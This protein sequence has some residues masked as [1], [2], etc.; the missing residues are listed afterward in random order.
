MPSKRKTKK[1]FT[2]IMLV[3]HRYLGFGL[4]V[5]FLFWFL[6]GFVMMYKDF[7]YLS[8]SEVWKRSEK[9]PYEKITM[10]AHELILAQGLE[11]IAWGSIKVT[12]LLGRPVYRLQDEEGILHCYYA[13]TGERLNRITQEQA[14]E[15]VNAFMNERYE[16]SEV[17]KT[18]Q[19]DQWTPRTR[20]LPYLPAYKVHIDDGEGTVCYISSVT[21]EVFQKL[22]TSDKVWAWLGPIPHWIYFKDLRIH[23]QLW[24]DIIVFLSLLGTI[25]CVAGLYM[26]IA[27]VKT[28][29][30]KWNSF[31][32][33]KKFWFKWHHYTGFAFGLITFTWIL[34][35]LFSM[36]PWR[37]SPSNSLSSEASLTW[38]GGGLNPEVFSIS[39]AQAL[40]ASKGI[41]E[42]ISELAY[43]RFAGQPYY[44]VRM[45][46]A[47]SRL[48][49]ADQ[50][51]QQLPQLSTELYTRQINR[52]HPEEEVL[53]VEVL[54]DY[55]A[56]YYNK[57][58]TKP[59]PVVK[60]SLG[61]D[62]D[63]SYY[64]DPK[65]TKVM[66]KY[67]TKS[68]VNRWLYHGLHSLD[69]PALFFK[70]P[71]WDIII[72]VLLLGGLSVSITGLALTYKWLTRKVKKLT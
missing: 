51:N 33:Y 8:K 45:S 5:L 19:L 58:R 64:I 30:R 22:N 43:M 68:R 55:D 54:Q 3:V 9:V 18:E 65:T 50:T 1:K 42:A 39:P 67:E 47:T 35:G 48:F 56:Y 31:S 32:P 66:M 11:D 61:D 62:K 16:I 14:I 23:T 52:L 53:R 10:T 63:T 29:N 15:I 34:S 69:F 27:R 44:L 26:G 13:D 72:L 46:D 71:L 25:M 57:H 20:F 36:N 37:W 59:L 38:Q 12:S 2:Q 24:R 17:E 60:V 4:S 21:G 28:K 41:D 49:F 7:P 70:R 40:D 6:S